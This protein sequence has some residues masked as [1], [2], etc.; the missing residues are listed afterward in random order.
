MGTQPKNITQTNQVKLSPQQQSVFDLALPKIQQYASSTPQLFASSGVSP[1]TPAELQAQ[2]TALDTAAPE[3]AQ[4]AS[5][6]AGTQKQL[7][8]PG[9]MLNPNQ[10]LQPAAEAVTRQ[11]TRNLT[12]SILPKIRSGA[13]SAGGQYTG[14]ATRQGIA[15]GLA[16]GRTSQAISDSLA[17]MYLQNYQK[18]LQGLSDA[19]GRTGTVQQQQLFPA[20][21]EAAVGA[22]QRGMGQAQLDEA[23]QKFYTQQDLPLL[24]S[25]Q[26]M[27]LIGQMPGATG[28][29]TVSPAKPSVN[30]LLMAIGLGSTV[31][32]LPFGPSMMMQGATGNQGG[33]SP[34]AGK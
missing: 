6:S 29:S 12:E 23:I 4:L 19:V 34:G 2:E 24:Q 17:N 20:N 16:T 31:A 25:Q 28:V 11:A 3:A 21:I 15:E 8:D 18:G 30:P 22:Q 13:T 9:F 14:G 10:Y 27:S 33:M 26:L 32:G 7:L 1:F 5:T